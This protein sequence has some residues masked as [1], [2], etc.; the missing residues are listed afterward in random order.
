MSVYWAPFR[1][2][3]ALKHQDGRQRNVLHTYG[4]C[5]KVSFFFRAASHNLLL[6]RTADEGEE[7]NK[8]RNRREERKGGGDGQRYF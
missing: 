8:R 1:Y 5:L 6:E 3:A 7:A 4:S 2:F